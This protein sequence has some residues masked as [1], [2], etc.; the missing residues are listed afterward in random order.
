M[1]EISTILINST[2]SGKKIFSE[3]DL[4]EAKDVIDSWTGRYIWTVYDTLNSRLIWLKK[5]EWEQSLKDEQIKKIKFL[6]LLLEIKGKNNIISDTNLFNPIKSKLNN[7]RNDINQYKNNNQ[8]IPIITRLNAEIIA[9]QNDRPI[10]SLDCQLDSDIDG[11]DD[12]LINPL[13]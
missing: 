10:N 12:C 8:M 3:N 4:L 5:F 2:Y 1:E 13:Q 7:L 9:I 11:N 6:L